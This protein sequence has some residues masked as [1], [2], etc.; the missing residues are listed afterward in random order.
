MLRVEGQS[1]FGVEAL[2]E[3]VDRTGTNIAEHDA[4]C[5]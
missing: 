3:T 5:G 2:P 4:E 1:V